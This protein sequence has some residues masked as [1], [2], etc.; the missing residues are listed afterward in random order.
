MAAYSQ[1]ELRP[2]PALQE[3]QDI[4]HVSQ[5]ESLSSSYQSDIQEHAPTNAPQPIERTGPSIQASPLNASPGNI[6]TPG[7]SISAPSRSRGFTSFF[8]RSNNETPSSSYN[9]DN[10]EGTAAPKHQAVRKKS[11]HF[12]HPLNDLR[13]FLHNHIVSSNSRDR[14]SGKSDKKGEPSYREKKPNRSDSTSY[15][16]VRGFDSPPWGMSQEGIGKKYGKWGR[17][18]GTGA[19]GTVRIIRRSKDHAQFAVKEFREK[20]P[21]EPEKEYIKKVTAEFCIGS[22]LHHVNIIKTLDIISNNGRYYEVMEYAPNELFAVVMS[23]KMGYNEINCVFRQIVDG[24]DYLHGLGLAHRDLKI[25]NCVV[26]SDGIVKIIDFGT[27]TVF[28]SP[29]KSKVL[30]SGIVGSD[31]YLAPEVLSRQTYDARLTDVWSLAIVYMCMILRRF[32]WKLP[33]PEVDPSFQI[34]VNAHPELCQTSG[35]PRQD[36]LQ[37]DTDLTQ[38]EASFESLLNVES[39]EKFCTLASGDAPHIP[40]AAE[41]G[42]LVGGSDSAPL[43]PI[44]TVDRRAAKDPQMTEEAASY[45][46]FAYRKPSQGQTTP[47]R[48]STVDEPESEQASRAPSPEQTTETPVNE[49]SNTG[50][51][52]GNAAAPPESPSDDPQPRAADSL[53]RLLPLAARPALS[54]MLVFEPDMRA[55]LGDLLRGRSYGSTDGPVSA[56]EY[57]KQHKEQD[58]EPS[59]QSI[60]QQHSYVDVFENDEDK[61]DDWLKSINTCSHWVRDLHKPKPTPNVVLSRDENTFAD[62]GFK[63]I[64]AVDERYVERPPPNHTHVTVNADNNRR[65]LFH[66]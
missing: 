52:N 20:R 57:A 10:T 11:D 54:R 1:E 29:G 31:P 40:T 63:S 59:P 8:H 55:T 42:Y 49:S 13:R 4:Y 3:A 38:A 19:G 45:G 15:R 37:T 2:A 24:V 41:A 27:A 23:G 9:E 44:T 53:F 5:P 17:T 51:A 60:P 47:Q 25:D 6:P 12:G 16:S 46:E 34:F 36:E 32:P 14:G 7:E 26:T 21:D 18:L 22:T 64:Y 58:L 66:R 61:G 50:S 62:M 30:A 33:D 48:S 39:S 35:A 43:T 28:Q 56:S 65:R